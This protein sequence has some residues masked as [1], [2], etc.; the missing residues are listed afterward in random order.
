MN[1]VPNPSQVVLL[2][3]DLN[4]T[5][6][7]STHLYSS[8]AQNATPTTPTISGAST[9]ADAHG[10]SFP[11]QVRPMMRR[12]MAGMNMAF[13]IQSIR[14]SFSRSVPGGVLSLRR[15]GCETRLAGAG[16]YGGLECTAYVRNAHTGMAMMIVAG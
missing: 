4:G 8:T 13:P 15:A 10:Y 5:V 2:A 6:G 9:C 14:P 16:G 3:I 7:C 12:E 1:V 11:P